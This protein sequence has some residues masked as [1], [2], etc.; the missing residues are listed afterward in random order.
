MPDDDVTVPGADEPAGVSPSETPK[1]QDAGVLSSQEGTPGPDT[2]DADDFDER[3]KGQLSDLRAKY[4][5]D[6][7]GL[8]SSLQKQQA[9]LQRNW[10]SE[11]EQYEEQLIRLK[12]A[13]MDDDERTAFERSLLEER[14]EKERQRRAELEARLQEQQAAQSWATWFVENGVPLA[15]LDT[16]SYQSVFE[17]GMNKL[18]E[19]AQ[20]A[21][22]Q[23]AAPSSPPAPKA[24]KVAVDTGTVSSG[25]TWSELVDRYGSQENVYRAVEQGW[26]DPTIIPD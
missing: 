24:P 17:T 10:E 16:T 3:V 6:I 9:E 22:R 21:Q 11:R 23:T 25:P 8:K 7:A 2:R 5:R 20:N 26:L 4:E 15:E 18:A 13:S 14:L 1:T 12:T 19:M